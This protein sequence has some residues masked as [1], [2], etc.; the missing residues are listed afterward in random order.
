MKKTKT[1][2]ITDIIIILVLLILCATFLYPYINQLAISLN[3]GSDSA[4]GGIYLIPRKFT[5]DITRRC[6]QIQVIYWRSLS[7]FQEL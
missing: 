1:D 7:A 2:K 3:E 6:F 4:R 5:F